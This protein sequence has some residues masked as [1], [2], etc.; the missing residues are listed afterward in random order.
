M[1]IVWISTKITVSELK[2]P[3]SVCLQSKNSAI[4]RAQTIIIRTENLW[5]LLKITDIA[6]TYENLW[7]LPKISENRWISMKISGH[8]WKCLNITENI[9]KLLFQL[10][11]VLKT[12]VGALHCQLVFGLCSVDFVWTTFKKTPQKKR[13]EINNRDKIN[14]LQAKN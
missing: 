2:Q 3:W 11:N 4:F 9:W 14:T 13:K 5:S 12:S 6:Y 8:L 7:T 10:W 1:L